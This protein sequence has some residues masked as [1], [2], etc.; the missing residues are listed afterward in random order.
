[1]SRHFYRLIY[2]WYTFSFVKERQFRSSDVVMSNTFLV[3][4]QIRSKIKSAY[5]NI[6]ELHA[7]AHRLLACVFSERHFMTFKVHISCQK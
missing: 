3:M 7:P 2:F 1:M 5:D 4:G 6:V